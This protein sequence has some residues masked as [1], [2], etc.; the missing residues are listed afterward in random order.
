MVRAARGELRRGEIEDPLAGP[1]RHHVHEAQQILVGITEA[2]A[3]ADPRL[4]ERRRSRQVERDHALVRVPHIDRAI[5]VRV[6][7]RHLQ[8]L[9][10]AVPVRAQ[11]L[12][13]ER[14]SRRIEVAREHR[15][16]AG[17]RDRLRA[18]WIEL[19]VAGVLR[20]AEDEDDLATLTR[21]ELEGHVM[22]SARR[23]PVRDRVGRLAALDDQRTIP[24][25]VRT[26]EPIE[27]GVE[28]GER[29]R[30][31]EVGEVIATLAIFGLV[32]DDARVDLDLADREIALE[33]RRVVPRVPQTELDRAEQRQRR[34]AVPSV[35][36]PGAPDLDGIAERDEEE[37][38]RLD[39]E[40]L[41]TDPRVTE[42]VRALVRVE[43]VVGR[44]PE[45][46]PELGRRLIPEVQRAPAEVGG[47]VVVAVPRH[48]A[49]PGVTEEGVAA[50]R[51]RDQ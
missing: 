36:D 33:V 6:R 49:E 34:G 16:R 46:R 3:A 12:E 29:F 1:L 28:A 4:E 32:I 47:H 17:L 7:G 10:Q 5:D 31:R 42:T 27:P 41:R 9:E 18:G 38:L 13:R 15:P 39:P 14:G 21:F 20:V 2:H 24:T 37:R 19:R 51:V 25:A 26:E 48:A 11:L 43:V 35:R 23:P 44:L 30:A 50:A 40:V 8:R 45:W 22:G